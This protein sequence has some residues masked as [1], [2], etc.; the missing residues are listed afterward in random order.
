LRSFI[1]CFVVSLGLVSTGA[2]ARTMETY[3]DSLTAGFLTNT[4]VTNAPSLKVISDIYSDL[5]MYKV[6][7]DK[8]YIAPYEPP[9]LGWPF[10]VARLLESVADPITIKNFAVS[11]AKTVDLIGQVGRNG[12]TLAPTMAFFFMGHNDL[13]EAKGTPEEIGRTYAATFERALIQWN[14]NHRDSAAYFMPVGDVHRVFE[15]LKGYVWHDGPV[16]KYACEDSWTRYFPY[17]PKYGRLHKEGKLREYLQ[18]KIQA[19]N[20]AL[21]RLAFDWDKKGAGNRFHY[22]KDLHDSP[23][24]ENF[25]AVDCFHLSH[26]GQ[27]A[28]A[29]RIAHKTLATF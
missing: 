24:Q 27:K 11:G 12:V 4:N 9:E 29:E 22:L 21:E 1:F 26:E 19:M 13:C 2:V 20:D 15:T 7:G 16:K 28:L 8:K 6:S 5:A 23:Y 3:G 14:R 10:A 18:P 25:F 17:C